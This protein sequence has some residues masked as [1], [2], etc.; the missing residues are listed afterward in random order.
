[1]IQY[2]GNGPNDVLI[3][4]ERSAINAILDQDPNLDI[5]GCF[6]IFVLVFGNAFKTLVSS[7]TI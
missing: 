7:S 5:K 4:F 6:S 1:M 3:N 2:N